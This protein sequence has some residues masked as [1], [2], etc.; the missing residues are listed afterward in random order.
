MGQDFKI[1]FDF[2]PKNEWRVFRKSI[3]FH[4]GTLS[5]FIYFLATKEDIGLFLGFGFLLF[6][7]P[8]LVLHFQYKLNDRRKKILVNHSM[9]IIRIEQN[10][11][12]EKE[13]QF[14]DINKIIRYKGQWDEENITYALPTFFYNYTEIVLNDGHKIFFTDFIAKNLGLKNIEIEEKLSLLNLIQ[15]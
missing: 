14:K 10:G 11:K 1:E 15:Y 3:I 9:Q 13:F 4:I 6:A 5:G 12:L 8:Q 7:L 2:D